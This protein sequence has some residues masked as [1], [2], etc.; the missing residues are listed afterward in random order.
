MMALKTIDDVRAAV[1]VIRA[2]AN[3]DESAHG[4]EDELHEAVLQA[5]ADGSCPD[6]KAWASAALESTKIRFSRWCA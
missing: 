2:E 5:I 6:P 4:T 1:E 3:D